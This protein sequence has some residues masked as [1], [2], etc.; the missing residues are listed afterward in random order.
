MGELKPRRNGT[1][2]T[3][4]P[5]LLNAKQRQTVEEVA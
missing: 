2:Q 5:M 3:V 4:G 1:I